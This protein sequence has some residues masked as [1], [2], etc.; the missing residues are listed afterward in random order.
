MGKYNHAEAFALM[1][2]RDRETGKVEIIWNSRDGVTPFI[3]L[4]QN[5]NESVHF[6]WQTDRI[7]PFHVPS[8]GDRIFVD[9][10][11]EKAEAFQRERFAVNTNMA[12]RLRAHYEGMDDEAIVQKLV[13]DMMSPGG[14]P[15]I[16]TV[17]GDMRNEFLKKAIA[18]K[19]IKTRFA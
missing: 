17:V 10:T 3:V 1:K 2:Y 4:S 6:D 12:E 15:D 8:V 5:G 16:A 19:R 9:L 14:Q 18:G 7:D 11:R 13:E